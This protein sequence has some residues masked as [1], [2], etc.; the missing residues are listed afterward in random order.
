[1]T[2]IDHGENIEELNTVLSVIKP[3]IN[4]LL[5]S[6]KKDFVFLRIEGVEDNS[7]KF[8]SQP[9]RGIYVREQKL[10]EVNIQD[11]LSLEQNGNELS[12]ETYVRNKVRS[13]L[14][15]HEGIPNCI[16]LLERTAPQQDSMDTPPH[17]HTETVSTEFTTI[18]EFR[19]LL[20]YKYQR[21]K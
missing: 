5:V 3:E 9:K 12:I 19:R 8:I 10:I 17:N 15:I 1:M 14:M 11:I 20:D 6:E 21:T 18:L 13:L 7:K 16:T 4:G 2:E